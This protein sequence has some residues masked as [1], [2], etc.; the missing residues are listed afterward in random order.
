MT[1]DIYFDHY[2]D[3]H[4]YGAIKSTDMKAWQDISSSLTFPKGI[5]HGTVLSVPES[6]VDQI[7]NH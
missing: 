5:R 7:E 6:V 1:N 2:V 4:Y 3:P